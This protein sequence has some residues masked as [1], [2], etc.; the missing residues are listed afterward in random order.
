MQV[1]AIAQ[2]AGEEPGEPNHH[3]A[4]AIWGVSYHTNKSADYETLNWGLG[5]RYSARPRWN[6]LLGTSRKNRVFLEGDVIRNSNRGLLVPLSAGAEYWTGLS[7]GGCK[8]FAV[9]A[10]TAAYY[11]YPARDYTAMKYGPVPGAALG[12]GPIKVNVAVVLRKSNSPLAAVVGS[13]TIGF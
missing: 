8:L 13:V 4:I 6:W 2:S 5:L 12:C 10:L 1:T 9:A 3:W 11:R 7:P